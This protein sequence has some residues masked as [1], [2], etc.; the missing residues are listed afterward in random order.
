MLTVLMLSK[1]K[2]HYKSLTRPLTLLKEAIFK[3]E[4]K[5]TL[6]N[7]SKQPWRRQ[8]EHHQTKAL[9]CCSSFASQS[10]NLSAIVSKLETIIFQLPWKLAVIF[11]C[12]YFKF[13]LNTTGLSQ[14]HFRNFLVCRTKAGTR[15]TLK[16]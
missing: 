5:E 8:R 1:L 2:R 11:T 3:W 6:R 9:N 15:H 12:K 10:G 14:S 4:G 13:G 7:S 16:S